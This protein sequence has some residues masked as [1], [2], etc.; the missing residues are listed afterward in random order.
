MKYSTTCV[1]LQTSNLVKH[2]SWKI[3]TDRNSK[4]TYYFVSDNITALLLA[5]FPSGLIKHS[6][7]SLQRTGLYICMCTVLVIN[8]NFFSQDGSFTWLT[9]IVN[10]I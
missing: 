6:T 3:E 4:M 7:L 5:W 2:L 8:L 10:V 1:N 9:L